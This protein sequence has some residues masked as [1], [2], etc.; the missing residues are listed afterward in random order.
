[1]FRQ[2]VKDEYGCGD[3]HNQTP[4]DSV[5]NGHSA[6]ALLGV[7]NIPRSGHS[8]PNRSCSLISDVGIISIADSKTDSDGSGAEEGPS[9]SHCGGF[10][11]DSVLTES[12]SVESGGNNESTWY[13]MK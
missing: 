6:V 7:M 11:S 9:I 2:H 13:T 12:E 10:P 3:S 5:I 8:S 4:S 1:M